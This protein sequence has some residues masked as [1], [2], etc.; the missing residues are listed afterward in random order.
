VDGAATL[1]LLQTPPIE[2]PTD[3][4][5]PRT[6]LYDAIVVWLGLHEPTSAWFTA[7]GTAVTT[8]FV[9]AFFDGGDD[10]AS[11]FGLFESNG[12]ALLVRLAPL[13]DDGD[14]PVSLGI[15]VHGDVKVGE[16]LRENLLAWARA[17]RPSLARLRIRAIPI[18]YPYQPGVGE[19]VLMRVCTRLVLQ[20]SP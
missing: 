17:G 7:H 11:S 5:V 4:V 6:E 8:R 20:W 15:R 14:S 12:V 13:S 3:L 18:E 19:I 1:R 16:R 10:A 2:L 9:P